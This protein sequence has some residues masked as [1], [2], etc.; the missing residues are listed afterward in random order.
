MN[1]L[2]HIRQR[3]IDNPK[4]IV[5]PES[6]DDRVLQAASS[7][8]EQG[9]AQVI[10]LGKADEIHER[11]AKLS[12]EHI[13]KS[14][15]VDYLSAPQRAS[16]AEAMCEI[17]KS[18]GLTQEQALALL[19]NPLYYATMMIKMGDAD[20]EVA[21]ATNFT[22]DV[23]RPAFQFVKTKP[24][25]S[26]VSG[27]FLMMLENNPYAP[28][29]VLVFADCA[30]NPD[31]NAQQLAEIAVSS[32]ETAKAI[33]GIDP[34]TAILSFST[35]G[36]AKHPMVDKVI[37]AGKIA[38]QLAPALAIESEIQADA[39]LVAAIASKKAP[40][41]TVAG[42]ANVLVFPS[43]EVGNIAYKLV[44]RL[45]GAKAI[46]P[47]L[48]GLNAPINDLSRGCCVEDIVNLTAITVNQANDNR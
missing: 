35:K 48:Q 28:E 3:A 13:A 39:A 5:L 1:L 24:G 10:L 43:L 45:A 23:L 21:G 42:K 16:Y 8:M 46:G 14:E 25:I 6:L 38:K 26:V 4:R 7:I 27:A 2:A 36:S 40:E 44:E 19:D 18:K 12:L 17:R 22:G 32:A 37:E 20:G 34:K 47:V 31:P 11:A 9:I 30:V 15:I 29:G 41:S 33:G